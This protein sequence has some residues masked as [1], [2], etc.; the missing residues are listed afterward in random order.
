MARNRRTGSIDQGATELADIFAVMFSVI[1]IVLIT[2]LSQAIG[3]AS[4][5]VS[6]DLPVVDVAESSADKQQLVILVHEN[7]KAL[8]LL[9]GTP[10]Q[11][12]GLR[13]HVKNSH[14]EIALVVHG[15]SRADGIKALR[16]R[17]EANSDI[18]IIMGIMPD[19]WVQT[20]NSWS[21]K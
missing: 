19:S 12:T 10:V 4:Q 6:E 21:Q 3:A 1:L 16:D 13:N 8:F 7:L 20:V 17:I 18:P 5:N 14:A 11:P 9:D 15:A 2:T